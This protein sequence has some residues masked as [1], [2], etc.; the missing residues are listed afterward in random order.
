MKK[1]ALH[2]VFSLCMLLEMLPALA[3]AA[4]TPEGA[5]AEVGYSVVLTL[6]GEW[7]SYG[8]QFWGGKHGPPWR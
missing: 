4:E 5:L 7:G 8:W 3:Q 1:R 6:P 2:L